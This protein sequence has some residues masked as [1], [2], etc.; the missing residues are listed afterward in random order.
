MMESSVTEAG[1]LDWSYH[2]LRGGGEV[3][4]EQNTVNSV[5]SNQTASDEQL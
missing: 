4:E 5:C 2:R 3:L 1:S